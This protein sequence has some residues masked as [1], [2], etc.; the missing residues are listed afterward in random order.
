MA[1]W[2]ILLLCA[3]NSGAQLMDIASKREPYLEESLFNLLLRLQLEET[4]DT[5]LVYGE[6]CLFHSLSRRLDVSTVLVSSGSTNFDWN[7]STLTLVL[8]CGFQ[9]EKEE[10]YRT[11]MKLQT[12][13]RLILLRDD[14]QPE[15]VCEYYTKKDQY[16][17]A[18]VKVDF[19]QFGE[20]NS[21]RI[22]QDRKYKKI[23]I[24]EGQHIFIE[25]FRNMRGAPIRTITDNFAPGCMIYRDPKTGEEKYTGF[26]ANL[27]VHFVKKVNATMAMQLNLIEDGGQISFDSISNW[28]SED[29]LDIGMSE[30]ASWDM[31]NY[32]TLSYP[33]LVTSHCFMVPLPDLVPFR[34][35]YMLIVDPPV[36]A[37]LFVIFCTISLLQFYTQRKSWRGLSLSGV[38]LNDICLRGFVAQPFPFPLQSSKK[39]KLLCLIVCFTSLMSTTMYLSYLQSFMCGLLHEPMMRSVLDVEKSR[40]KVAVPWFELDVLLSFNI[41]K[42][43]MLIIED[44]DQFDLLRRSFDGNFIYPIVEARWSTFN[45]QQ[46]LF[47]NPMFYYSDSLCLYNVDT[48]TIPIR[49]HLPYRDL[50]EEH[51]MRQH[52]FGLPMYW[53]ARSFMDMV[54]LKLTPFQDLSPPRR[55]DQIEIGDIVW[56]LGMFGAGLGINKYDILLI[57]GEDCVFPSL[58]RRLPISTVLVSSGSTNFDWNFGS[59]TLIISCGFQAEK[60]ENYRTRMKLQA[61]RRLILLRED[62]QPETVCEYYTK[63]DQYNIAMVKVDFDQDGVV[64]SCRFFQDQKYEKINIFEGQHIFIEQFRNMR[65]APIRTISDNLAPGCMIYRDPKSGEEKYTGFVANLLNNFVEKVNATMEMQV[66]LNEA[67]EKI[68]FVNISKWTAEDLLD[69]GMSESASWHMWNYDTL[70]YPYLITSHCFMVPLPDLVSYNDLYLLIIDPPVLAA[71]FV[72]Y[73]TISLLQF[74][75]QRKSWRGLSLSRMLTNDMCLRGFLGQSFPFSRHSSRKLKLLC[76]IVCF[77][78]VMLTTMYVSYLQSF[79]WGTLRQPIMLSVL[80]VERSRYKVAIPSFELEVLLSLN[81]SVEKLLI[82]E[83]ASQFE[84]LRETFNGDYIYPIT[85]VRW[86]TFNEQQKLFAYPLF[87]YSHSLCLYNVDT[88]TVPIRRHLPYRDL[89]EEHILRQNEFGLPRY[90]IDRSFTDMLWL[91]LK[92][93]EDLSPPLLD[94]EIESHVCVELPAQCYLRNPLELPS[95]PSEQ[96]PSR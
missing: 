47:A 28:T 34:E 91:K 25:Q 13:R 57:Y 29:L 87:Y 41:T 9:A 83:D 19:D 53:I 66:N 7:F 46:K 78:S 20:V 8:S 69:I 6:D 14:I 24:F 31:S 93:Y 21:C 88:Y 61:N 1:W 38:L 74:Y 56:V 45:E 60:E 32:D 5:L 62:I 94:D 49:R 58:T 72:I 48:L 39:L 84:Q 85:E 65:G 89:F 81:L 55:N 76:L 33:Y 22:F 51:I 30:G 73:C 82:F 36:L 75:T 23:N 35:L 63:K 52:E 90:W 77:T 64:H 79:M 95:H 15:T 59:L 54:T 3:G 11:R 70:S 2:V 4:Y 18:M 16:N 71:L 86:I 42:E 43:K 92:R 67:G 80:D 10:N 12:N 96:I 17:I 40:Y 44:A 68:S 27:I 50:F 37:A 26:L